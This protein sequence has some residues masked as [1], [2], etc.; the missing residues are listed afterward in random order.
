MSNSAILKNATWKQCNNKC[1]KIKKLEH[2][3]VQ[4]LHSATLVRTTVNSATS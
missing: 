4:H 1:Y 2:N 3:I